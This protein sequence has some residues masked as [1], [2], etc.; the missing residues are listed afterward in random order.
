MIRPSN[1]TE[2]FNQQLKNVKRLFTKSIL[3]H[4]KQWNIK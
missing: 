3:D 1:E 2:D 4:K